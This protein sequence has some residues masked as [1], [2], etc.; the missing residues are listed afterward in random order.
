MKI[1][2][3]CSSNRDRRNKS[4][5]YFSFINLSCTFAHQA[6]E[7]SC[8]DDIDGNIISHGF[9]CVFFFVIVCLCVRSVKKPLVSVMKWLYAAFNKIIMPFAHTYRTNH[10]IQ[11]HL[12]QWN[13]KKNRC[14][15]L[16]YL[17]F[18][19]ARYDWE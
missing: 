16:T 7:I 19:L 8:N 11:N 4:E 18:H 13:L 2:N 12:L 10:T 15:T 9:W 14:F 17:Y 5:F 1:V 6:A 3:F